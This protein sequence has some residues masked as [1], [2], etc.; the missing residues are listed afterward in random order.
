MKLKDFLNRTPNKPFYQ[1]EFG[2]YCMDRWIEDGYIKPGDDLSLLFGFDPNEIFYLTDA[3]GCSAPFRPAFEDKILENRG[4]Y[5]L[6]QDGAGRHVLYFKGRR[7]GFMPEYVN[8]PVKDILSWER[9][10]LWRMNPHSKG[11]LEQAAENAVRAASEHSAGKTI[12]VYLVG[13]Y[14]YLRSLIGPIELL[15]MF[16]DNPTLIHMCMNAWFE[17]AD[18]VIE[19]YQKYTEID[20]ILFDEDICYK[21]GSLISDD[22]ICEFLKPY[23]DSIIKKAKKRSEKKIHIELATD[24]YI[25]AVIDR[26]IS[27]EFNW[28][29]PFEVAADCDV[30]EIGRRYP[31]ILISGGIDKRILA[32]N[33]EAIDRMCDRIF[34]QML[35]RGGYFP[36]CD[37]GVPEEVPFY[38][39]L[40]Y[41][42]R[43][44]EYK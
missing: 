29:S 28:F 6:V 2:Y 35:A 10:C 12:K 40:H 39:Y 3:G 43:C 4:K 21:T 14:M 31:D 34:P 26:Y 1:C 22:M 16:Y 9:E 23:Y 38:N 37:H 5:E 41:R 19:I 42:K 17:V 15:Y 33:C 30:V 24:G 20:V 32:E 36:T 11:R 44:L 25:P 18:A 7:N 27:M 8:H 13:G